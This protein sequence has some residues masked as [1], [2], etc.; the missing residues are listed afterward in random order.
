MCVSCGKLGSN[1]LHCRARDRYK[2]LHP[3]N[4]LITHLVPCNTQLPFW[5]LSHHRTSI[6]RTY[7]MHGPLSFLF[8]GHTSYSNHSYGCCL[9]LH[10][11]DS[12]AE[13]LATNTSIPIIQSSEE[14]FHVMY[15][16][17]EA[18]QIPLYD[19]LCHLLVEFLLVDATSPDSSRS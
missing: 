3:E 2:V 19:S 5:K 18:A 12:F 10:C 7:C 9:A 4:N 17:S 11:H 14:H 1:L 8:F 16:E 13:F 15:I 6:V